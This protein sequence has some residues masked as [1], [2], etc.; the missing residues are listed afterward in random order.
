MSRLLGRRVALV[1]G[2]S[3]GLG[4]AICRRFAAEG[5]AGTAF[6]LPGAEAEATAALPHGFAFA[7]GDVRDEDALA[8]AVADTVDRHGRL[9]ILVA[10]AGLV[11]PWRETEALD[12]DEWDRVMAVNVRGVAAALKQAIPALKAAGGGTVVAMASVNAVVAHPRQMLYTA[13][14]H[15][16]LGIVRAAA[17]DLGR[18]G[19][20]VNGL[21][22]GPI[23]TEAL[24][25]RIAARA[26]NGTGPASDAA[27]DS[28]AAATALGRLATVD[29]VAKAALFLACDLSSGITGALLP[30]D[31]GL[32]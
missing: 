23:A 12:F 2:A 18:H 25:A 14:K 29:D 8:A 16:V 24:V 17:R 19:I 27:L 7:G 4:L 10:N 15:A 21:A 20:R 6:D 22:P 31:A 26:E 13:S 3:R 11:P 28:F 32:A 9:D 1:T 30:V 5:A